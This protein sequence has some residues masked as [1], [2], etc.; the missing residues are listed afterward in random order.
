[1]SLNHRAVICI[2]WLCC[3]VVRQASAQGICL[4]LDNPL[5]AEP[6]AAEGESERLEILAG[7][8][9]LSGE[10]AVVSEEV[11]IRYL[12][13]TLS[14]ERATYDRN[15]ER[16]EAG[17]RVTFSDSDIVIFGEDAALDTLKEEIS[18]GAAGF[19]LPKRAARGS[20]GEIRL[21]SDKTVS[22]STVMFT[23]CPPERTT[24]ELLAK[25]LKLDV[26]E[27]F[28]TARGVKLEFKGVPILYSP[29]LTFP[30]DDQRKSGFLT[31]HFAERD[32]TG[33]DIGIPYYFNLAPNYDLLLEPNYLR[34]RGVQL[35]SEFRYL[36]PRSEG[37]F[38]LE[39]LPDDSET[40][41]TRNYINLQHETSFGQGW[42]LITGIEEVSDENYFEDLGSS[43]SVTSQTHLNRYLDL[44]FF[45]PRWSL[46]TR[47]QNYQTIDALIAP[48]DRPYERVPQMLFEG[49]WSGRLVGFDSV[50]EL[51]NFDRDIG[52]TG[53]R[54]DSTQELSLRFA[55]AGRYLTPAVALRSTN[56]Y[57]NDLAP[58]EN[59]TPTRSL[60]IFS[61]DSGIKF[62]R[63]AGKNSGWIQTLEPRMLYVNVPFEDQSQLPVFDTIMPD[64]NL[65]Q[66]FRKYQF[67]GPDR[68][69]DKE[70][71]SFGITTRF[72]DSD[73]GRERLSATLGQTRFLETQTVSLP[74]GGLTDSRE[75]DYVAE[76]SVNLGETWNL[77]VGYQ[78]NGET[79]ST[80][81]SETRFEYRP[82]DDRLFSLAYRFRRG[83]LEQSDL[84]MVWPVGDRWR[85]IGRYSYSLLEEEPLEQFVGWEYDACCW[86]IRVVGRQYV[87]RRTGVTDN[88]LSIELELKGL[89]Q[90]SR[91]PEE[92]LDRGILGYRRIAGSTLQ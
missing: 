75:S 76:L 70:Q 42:K 12:D 78:W 50:T 8:F 68:I 20:A 83:L 33:L 63:S 17:G 87:S 56:Y 39:Y 65:I 46:L 85:V 62:E 29:Y 60:P 47:F 54:L 11:E 10:E 13:G 1:M 32:R 21:S 15:R 7:D 36:M 43:L 37:Q 67:V 79:D 34:K 5:P 23:S 28:G 88:A 38:T 19:D 53:W 41:A 58:G 77:D 25:E 86:R 89:T 81:R 69:S 73:T 14:A 51:V 59:D 40:N 45:A 2:T 24:W 90:R 66:L 80:A 16:F 61:I 30:I 57:L 31:P 71:L 48:E 3:C 9:E 4:P 35:N 52:V 72:I 55:R 18:F 82:Q 6:P 84:S 91:S 92:L 64:F 22:L 49:R 44:A 74:N 26:E 27:G